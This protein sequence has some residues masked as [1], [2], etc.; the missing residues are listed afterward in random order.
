MQNTCTRI[1]EADVATELCLQ[2]TWF[3]CGQRY[4]LS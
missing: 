2:G 1:G 4:L 3:K